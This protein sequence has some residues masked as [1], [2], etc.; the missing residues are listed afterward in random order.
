MDLVTRE[1]LERHCAM[2]QR[3]DLFPP[4]YEAYSDTHVPFLGYELWPVQEDGNLRASVYIHDN[5]VF[6][7]SKILRIHHSAPNQLQSGK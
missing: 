7:S 1:L 5:K 6:H 2:D 3:L 4:Q